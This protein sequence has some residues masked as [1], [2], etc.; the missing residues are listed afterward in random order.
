MIEIVAYRD[1]NNKKTRSVQIQKSLK[2]Y[3]IEREGIAAYRIKLIIEKGT[4]EQQ[5]TVLIRNQGHN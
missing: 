3:L 4:V 1:L 5:R 2:I